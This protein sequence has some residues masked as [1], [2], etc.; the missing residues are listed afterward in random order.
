M[1]N[2]GHGCLG[3]INMVSISMGVS[4][5]VG[6]LKMGGPQISGIRGDYR[7]LLGLT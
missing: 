7:S 1:I 3:K 2:F 4:V 6:V 5:R